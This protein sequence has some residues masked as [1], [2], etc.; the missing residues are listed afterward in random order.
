MALVLLAAYEAVRLWRTRPEGHGL[1]ALLF[2]EKYRLS[3]AAMLIGLAGAGIFLLFGA[4]GYTSTFELFIEGAFGTKPWPV[5]TRWLL[6][7][8]VLL[9]MLLS[10]LQRGSFRLD[11]RP[12][13]A[14]LR[15][16]AGGALMGFGVALTPGGNDGLVLYGIP[17]LSPHAIPAYLALAV[18]VV[19]GDRPDA[20]LLRDRDAGGMPER[21]L[22]QR[23]GAEPAA[24]RPTKTALN[25]PGRTRHLGGIAWE[26]ARSRYS[27]ASQSCRNV[28]GRRSG[29][30]LESPSCD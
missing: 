22:L 28:R 29:F 27:G 14:W 9:G 26:I 4:P 18:G 8:A 1:G 13:R 20:A 11:L 17:S 2:A 6:L 3:T 23:L 30:E 16:V 7:L 10:T 12:R 15:N 21:C 19:G 24:V 5:A 25:R